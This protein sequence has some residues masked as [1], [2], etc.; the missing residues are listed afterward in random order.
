[1]FLWTVSRNC[2]LL[3]RMT[4][5]TKNLGTQSLSFAP[6]LL[7]YPVQSGGILL[8]I[9][10]DID[11]RV[12]VALGLYG[13]F[14]AEKSSLSLDDKDKQSTSG[15]GLSSMQSSLSDFLGS[16]S[17][18]G[19]V[20]VDQKPDAISESKESKS[21]KS[22]VSAPHPATP[23]SLLEFMKFEKVI[24]RPASPAPL[25]TSKSIKVEASESEQATPDAQDI[26][27]APV[28]VAPL[29]PARPDEH[30]PLPQIFPGF[31][32]MPMMNMMP[33]GIEAPNTNNI[34]PSDNGTVP[35]P[36]EPTEGNYADEIEDED[37]DIIN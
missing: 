1:M 31:S 13:T 22:K 27:E 36:P 12:S 17:H 2:T 35:T 8:D 3:L 4:F 9:G 14:S 10:G 16:G 7:R 24:P 26:Q 32:M 23:K 29:C 19:K 33:L 34:F 37:I 11:S 28:P 25:I 15:A 21:I 30:L 18:P 6:R 5:C 20:L